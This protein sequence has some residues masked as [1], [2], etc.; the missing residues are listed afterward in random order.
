MPENTLAEKTGKPRAEPVASYLHT[1]GLLAIFAVAM[2]IGIAMQGHPLPS[3]GPPAPAERNVIPMFLSSLAFGWGTV[4]YVWAG[5]HHRGGNLFALTGR[6]WSS[7]K[8]VLRDLL[9]AAP[10]W[11]VWEA[12]AYGMWELLGTSTANTA[13]DA[14]F[15]PRGALEICL[16]IAVSLTAG[17]CEELIFRGYLQRQLTA[18]TGRIWAAVILQGIFFGLLH[19]RGWK[20]VAVISVLGMLYG[21]L[22]AWRKDLKPGM[23]SHGWS[24]VWEGWLKHLLVLPR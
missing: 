17:F 7:L 8:D 18:L 1:L 6:R 22:A 19:P 24:D 23:L 21:T 3:G 5:V 15:P 12:V 9:I 20:A 10:F 13:N 11:A 2:A 14:M 16:W 4:Y